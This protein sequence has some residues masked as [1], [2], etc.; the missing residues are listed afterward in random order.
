MVAKKHPIN[1]KEVQRWCKGEQGEKEWEE[2][3]EKLK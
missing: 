1:L 2:F 3:K